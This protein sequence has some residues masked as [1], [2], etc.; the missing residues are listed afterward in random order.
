MCDCTPSSI[1]PYSHI[2]FPP[3]SIH[4]ILF[5]SSFQFPTKKPQNLSLKICQNSNPS[6]SH[7][8]FNE[9]KL[10]DSKPTNTQFNL[11]QRVNKDSNFIQ[12]DENLR[13]NEDEED[14]ELVEVEEK[15]KD[16]V[17]VELREFDDDKKS[18][19]KIVRKGKELMKRGN[20]IAKQVISIQSALSLGFISQL[21]V[22]TNTVSHFFF[23]SQI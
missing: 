12:F 10:Q 8:F 9:L 23:S 13:E 19:V 15:S 20:V 18:K 5:L 1:S 7:Q 11:D 3:S 4:T 6:N 16:D 22:D 17:I 21:W 14:D 2:K